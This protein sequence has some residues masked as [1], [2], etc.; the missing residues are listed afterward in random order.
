VWSGLTQKTNVLKAA[1]EGA[2]LLG[3]NAQL[4]FRFHQLKL[5]WSAPRRVE[6]RIGTR[7]Q[8]FGKA[9]G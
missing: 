3:K 5:P 9:G 4:R 6:D 2:R 7:A 1:P 8:V